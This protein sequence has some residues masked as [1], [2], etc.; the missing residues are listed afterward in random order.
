MGPN[1]AKSHKHNHK[2]DLYNLLGREHCR[3]PRGPV[4]FIEG[5]KPGLY[6]RRCGLRTARL[7]IE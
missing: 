5:M 7:V 6:L 4:L 1:G 3:Q 2:P